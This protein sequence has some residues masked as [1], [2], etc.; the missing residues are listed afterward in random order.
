M[1]QSLQ[2]TPLHL[3]LHSPGPHA[4]STGCLPSRTTTRAASPRPGKTGGDLE[5][6][7]KAP[8]SRNSNYYLRTIPGLAESGGR[9]DCAT[10]ASGLALRKNKEGLILERQDSLLRGGSGWCLVNNGEIRRA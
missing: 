7:Q 5:G 3:K 4:S 6:L 9:R 8:W 1:V 2:A 10:P